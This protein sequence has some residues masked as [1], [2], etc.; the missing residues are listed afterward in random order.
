M[1]LKNLFMINTV[2]ALLFGL[3][4]VLIP[5]TALGWYGIDLLP[6]A[7]ILMSRLFGSA[8]LGIAILTW[9][10]RSQ[11]AS[12]AR[13]AI[14]T[15]LLLHD[16][17]G[18]IVGLLAQLDGVANQLGWSTVIIYLLLALGYGYFRFVKS[19]D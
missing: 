9:L 5:A 18:F 15:G 11:G 2:I 13:T 7:G 4:F 17:L 3:A 19:G 6:K 10:V 12:E 14:I 1:N 16:A 8:L